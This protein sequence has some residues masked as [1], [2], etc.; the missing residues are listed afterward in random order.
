MWMQGTSAS[1]YDTIRVQITRGFSIG[2]YEVTQ[3]DWARVVAWKMRHGG[4]TLDPYPSQFSGEDRP[5][6]RVSWQSVD[7]WLG[8]LN[9][10]EGTT[11]YRLPTEAEW[12]FAARG[13]NASQGYPYSGG[14]NP[15]EVGWLSTA[16]TTLTSTFPVGQKKPNEL[17]IFDMTGNVWEWCRDPASEYIL[18]SPGLQ[19]LVDPTGWSGYTGRVVRGSGFG[20]IMA[21]VNLRMT[22]SP[23]TASQYFGFRVVREQ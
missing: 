18:V 15:S 1:T 7:T 3:S 13:G 11:K 4:T 21:D 12:E 14:A 17:G 20:S 5:V 6:E 10:M 9:E 2:T 22:G 8:Y 23:T 16:F 19:V